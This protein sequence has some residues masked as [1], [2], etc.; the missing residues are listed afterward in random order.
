MKANREI[1]KPV[2]ILVEGLDCLYLLLQSPLKNDPTF[3][4]NT[5]LINYSENGLRLG[6]FLKTISKLRGFQRDIVKRLGVI[7]DAESSRDATIQ[8]VQT[9]LAANKF[10]VPDQPGT[11]V[12]G[13]PAVSFLIIP[14]DE[15]SGCLEHACLKALALPQLLPCAEVFLACVNGDNLNP[16]WQ[17]KLKVHSI[18]AGSGRNPAMTLGQSADPAIGLW[19][20]DHPSLRVMVDFV[21]QLSNLT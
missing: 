10:P 20:F 5:I 4:A 13:A 16:N 6:D 1:D 15:P 3:L 12:Q 21:K 11:L 17:A 9:H 2:V 7:C 19:R 18:I 8:S 14:H